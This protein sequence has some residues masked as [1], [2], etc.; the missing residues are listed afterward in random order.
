MGRRVAALLRDAVGVERVRVASRRGEVRVDVRRPETL[1]ALLGEGDV[2]ID[3]VGPYRHDPA[4]LVE[5]CLAAGAHYVDL[6]ESPEFSQA[7]RDAAARWPGEVRSAILTGCSTIPALVEGI[8]PLMGDTSPDVAR[9]DVLLSMGSRNPASAGLLYSLMRPLGQ[10]APEQERWWGRATTRVLIDG[11]QRRYGNF[12][13]AW[14]ARQLTERGEQIDAHFWSGFDRQLLWACLWLASWFLPLIP[15]LALFILCRLAVPLTWLWRPLGT[16][17]GSL[18]IE[19]TVIEGWRTQ[20]LEIHAARRGLMIPA[21]PAAWAAARLL[22][23]AEV[24]GVS[25]LGQLMSAKEMVGALQGAGYEV[26][27]R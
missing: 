22:E 26:I 8:L 10:P 4:P 21:M 12:P 13:S 5:R 16:R 2:L 25:H 24:S 19:R 9:V 14:S 7:V 23:G 17:R 20:S 18:V 11:R 27:R 1:D 3:A 6:S 15:D